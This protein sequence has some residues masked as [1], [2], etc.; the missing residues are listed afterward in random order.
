M[1]SENVDFLWAMWEE[2]SRSFL[3]GVDREAAERL[4]DADIEYVEDPRWP[5]S[6]SYRGRDAV[7]ETW[8]GYLDVLNPVELRVED[9]IDAGDQAVAL[10]RISGVS[11][12][13][14]VPFEH[15][16]AYVCRV[17]GGKLVYQRAYW[18]VEEA[19]SAAGVSS[20]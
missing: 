14:D 15:L 3:T 5:G 6:R 8:N 7:I 13:A 19:L 20:P 9:L 4:W 10:V 2:M 11:K 18:D 12:G 1:S 16:W 17:E